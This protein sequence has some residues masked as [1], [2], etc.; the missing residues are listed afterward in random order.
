MAYSAIKFS[1]SGLPPLARV[2]LVRR[3]SHARNQPSPKSYWYF[4][5]TVIASKG[6]I[7]CRAQTI[8]VS[9]ASRALSSAP[10]IS[11]LILGT[12]DGTERAD[13]LIDL[14]H[15][16]F[17]TIWLLHRDRP[18]PFHRVSRNLREGDY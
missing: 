6:A 4:R 9:M 3:K 7:F 17:L 13:G 8:A 10:I 15:A 16:R 2:G 11:T 18:F 5:S 12:M 14:L 1:S